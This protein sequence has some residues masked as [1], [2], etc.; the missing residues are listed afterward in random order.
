MEVG[1]WPTGEKFKKNVT[2]QSTERLERFS[3]GTVGGKWIYL[4]NNVYW[5]CGRMLHRS[6]YLWGMCLECYVGPTSWPL[7][8]LCPLPDLSTL[9]LATS[10]SPFKTQLRDYAL[11]AAFHDSYHPLPL[12]YPARYGLCGEVAVIP[13]AIVLPLINWLQIICIYDCLPG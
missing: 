4:V 8:V 2:D 6:Q 9:N 12:K 1:A 3:S 5:V 7:H 13:Y 10:N 11:Q